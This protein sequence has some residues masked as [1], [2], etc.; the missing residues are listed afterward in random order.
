MDDHSVH[1]SSWR[2]LFLLARTYE[3]LQRQNGGRFV[4]RRNSEAR[5]EVDTRWLVEELVV[6]LV[7]VVV[8]SVEELDQA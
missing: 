2:C 7:V 5:V 3:Y 1:G 8:E 6:V 4:D